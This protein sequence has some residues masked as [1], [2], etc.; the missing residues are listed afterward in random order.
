[1]YYCKDTGQSK[2]C[3]RKK[4]TQALFETLF[5]GRMVPESTF[6]AFDGLP[7]ACGARFTRMGMTRSG[8]QTPPEKARRLL[9]VFRERG[10]KE[11]LRVLH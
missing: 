10:A 3:V 9:F 2:R 6:A 5:D 11:A 7:E 1:M 8:A 4:E